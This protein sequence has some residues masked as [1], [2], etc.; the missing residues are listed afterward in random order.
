MAAVK[1][2]VREAASDAEEAIVRNLFSYY[3]EAM[4]EYDPGIAINAYGLPVWTGFTGPTP[5]TH[6]EAVTFNWWIRDS[7]RRF[8][9]YADD[10][11]A[12][13]VIVN[14]GP[15]FIAPDVDFDVQDFFVLAKFRRRGVGEAAARAIFDRF[16]GW[17][18]VV[19]LARNAPAI[20]FW[21]GVVG[22]YTG[23]DYETLDAGAR[24]RFRNDEGETTRD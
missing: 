6:D 20:A 3:F 1:V 23:G 8:L 2:D 21:N 4:S 17:W 5:R 7:C 13:F 22:A 12:G 24:Q 15:H 11:P 16:R 19:Q 14:S 18:E 10:T 9:I